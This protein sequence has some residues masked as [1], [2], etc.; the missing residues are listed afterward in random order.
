[1]YS[2]N[3][4]LISNNKAEGDRYWDGD[5]SVMD[6][7]IMIKGS[8]NLINDDDNYLG[9]NHGTVQPRYHLPIAHREEEGGDCSKYDGSK[10][11]NRGDDHIGRSSTFASRTIIKNS[12]TSI[13]DTHRDDYKTCNNDDEGEEICPPLVESDDAYF[14]YDS[15]LEYSSTVQNG[16]AQDDIADRRRRLPPPV[17]SI[18]DD[19][20]SNSNSTSSQL[21]L[22]RSIILSVADE[23]DMMSEDCWDALSISGLSPSAAADIIKLFKAKIGLLQQFDRIQEK[24][25]GVPTI[26]SSPSSMRSETS[27]RGHGGEAAGYPPRPP[28]I[29]PVPV[30]KD[31]ASDP[32]PSTDSAVGC[33]EVVG[34]DDD[35]WNPHPTHSL[36]PFGLRSP[37]IAHLLHTWTS[38]EGKVSM[39]Q[40]RRSAAVTCAVLCC[41]PT[42]QP[43][44]TTSPSS[45]FL[46]SSTCSDGSRACP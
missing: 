23:L 22:M 41:A 17:P 9:G 19:D 44:V 24:E 29:G 36:P 42:S 43:R 40:L 6:S 27:R 14:D 12:T 10:H 30:G 5:C 37:E 32:V 16:I 21:T 38:D 3:K 8:T 11:A 26:P 13:Y 39:V 18:Y 2:K 1:M 33:W 31:S 28:S 46:R 4:P 20:D 25:E 34:D 15:V 45:P 7:S 35:D